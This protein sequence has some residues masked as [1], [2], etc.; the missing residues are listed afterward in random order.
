L[1]GFFDRIEDGLAPTIEAGQG[2]VG[3]ENEV[4]LAG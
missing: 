2:D 1:P 4:V 3:P